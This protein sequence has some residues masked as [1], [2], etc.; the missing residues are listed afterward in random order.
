VLDFW[1]TIITTIIERLLSWPVAVLVLGLVFRFHITKMLA[2]LTRLSL[3]HG[4][5]S[6]DAQISASAATEQ[7]D[8]V[9]VLKAGSL[10]A[11]VGEVVAQ[12]ADAKALAVPP[13]EPVDDAARQ[14]MIDF[15]KNIEAVQ[16]RENA[17][18]AHLDR[19]GFALGAP[20]TTEI[21][22]RNLAF[23][24]AIAS[25]E[26]LYR[27]IFGSQIALLKALNVG[28]PK[29]ED[30]VRQF[31]ERA[32]R[33]APK[34]YGDYQYETWRDFLLGQAA[35][36]RDAETGLYGITQNGREFLSWMVGQG[37]AE[38]KIG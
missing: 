35:I 16:F 7:V 13:V 2:R 12:E 8:K 3:R 6:I 20:L 22:I 34:F 21:L 14:A 26:R 1:K 23:N 36:A 32:K 5:T 29:T 15:A 18:K 31:F 25:A 19:M 27:L 17:I 33:K 10:T 9:D 28:T 11:S 37:I 24:Q 38:D 30:E 4:E